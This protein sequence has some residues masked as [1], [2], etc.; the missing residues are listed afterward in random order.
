MIKAQRANRRMSL[1]PVRFYFNLLRYPLTMFQGKK[2]R[3]AMLLGI[4]QAANAAG[5][6]WESIRERVV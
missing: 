5:F 2:I 6:F 1:E 4:S 3:L